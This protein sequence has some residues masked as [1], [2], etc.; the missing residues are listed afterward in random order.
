MSSVI[1]WLSH[2]KDLILT[3][4]LFYHYPQ[5]FLVYIDTFLWIYIMVYVSK[6]NL[7]LPAPHTESEQSHHIALHYIVAHNCFKEY[8]Y[9][10]RQTEWMMVQ[11]ITWIYFGASFIY[12]DYLL[13]L[14]WMVQMTVSWYFYHHRPS[15]HYLLCAKLGWTFTTY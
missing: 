15:I 2:F 3:P 11:T 1:L 13:I 14:F 6:P 8:A 12:Q 9:V 10:N 7:G 5:L 4:I